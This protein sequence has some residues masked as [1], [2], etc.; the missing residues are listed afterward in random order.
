MTDVINKN[1][2]PL[3]ENLDIGTA[4]VSRDGNFLKVNPVFCEIV[5]YSESEILDKRFQDITHPSDVQADEE[6]SKKV[7]LGEHPGYR[8]IKRYISKTNKVVWVE[9]IVLSISNDTFEMFF[10]QIL[11]IDLEKDCDIPT[12]SKLNDIDFVGMLKNNWKFFISVS[13]FLVTTII[14]IGIAFWTGINQ[15]GLLSNQVGS[16]S[17]DVSN[18]RQT[19]MKMV[20]D[21]ISKQKNIIEEIKRNSKE[22]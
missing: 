1:W 18:N 6:M 11:P 16:L 19:I 17:E 4:L 5:G 7:I 15:L 9:L 8:M 10:V 12:P 21:E 20:D 2:H 14:G 13:F 3:F 22:E